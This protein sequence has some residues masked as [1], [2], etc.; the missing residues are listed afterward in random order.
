MI[1]KWLQG[2]GAL[3]HF[4]NDSML[5][6]NVLTAQVDMDIVREFSELAL[7]PDPGPDYLSV[8]PWKD[9][10]D[11][12]WISAKTEAAFRVFQSAFERMDVAKYVREY[13]DIDHDVHFYAGFVHTRRVCKE[14]NFH[15]DWK[16]T[17]NEA[18][19][20]LTPV[21]GFENEQ[22][23]LYKKLTG[24]VAEYVYK[25]GEAI[26]FGDHFIHSTPPGVADPP[27]GLLVLYFGSDK[28]EH[29]GKLLRTQGR[30]AALLHRPDGEFVHIDPWKGPTGVDNQIEPVP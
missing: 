6:P 8:M 24:E 14:A 16:L 1:L 3:K 23:L 4:L 29:W 22:K 26:I 15:V 19:T 11:I 13:L 21:C 20:L 25:P 5:A 18:F 10:N 9:F 2:A 30:Q 12:L 28:M 27:F 7:N 17:N